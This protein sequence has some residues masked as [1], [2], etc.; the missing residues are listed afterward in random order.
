MC[1]F[2]KDCIHDT[3]FAY[4]SRVKKTLSQSIAGQLA[5]EIVQGK[6]PPGSRLDEQSIARRFGVSRSPVRDALRSLASTRLVGYV[7]HRG[8][9]VAEVDPA[10]LDDLFEAVSEIEAL[11]ARLCALRASATDRKRIELLH[12]RARA[13]VEHRDA[14]AYSDLNEEFHHAIYAGA[15]NKTIES[16]ATSLRQRLAPFR[17]RV[18]FAVDNRMHR[19]I[20]EHAAVVQAILQHDAQAAADRMRDHAAYSAMNALQYLATQKKAESF[21]GRPLA[22]SIGK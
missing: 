16:T 6:L 20:E 5:D 13:S 15:R 11:C 21:I 18:F 12:E 22:R 9:S 17:S 19:S 1:T 4:S 2:V 8:F 7:T 3:L 10:T 14:A